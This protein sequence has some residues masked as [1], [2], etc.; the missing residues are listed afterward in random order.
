VPC[1]S[2]LPSLSINRPSA[3]PT[4][5]PHDKTVPLA[6]NRPVSGVIGRTIDILNSKVVEPEPLSII[7]LMASPMHVSRSVAEKS[8]CTVPS[9]LRYSL[10]G[11][12]VTTTLPFRA[13]DNVVSKRSGHG[14]QW[15]RSVHK[16][17]DELKPALCLPIL[18]TYDPIT[19]LAGYLHRFYDR[20]C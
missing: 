15:Q 10:L 4:R 1:E 14:V 11:S 6:L 18:Y 19:L 2:S 20:S 8:P 3:V 9:G 16:P 7:D 5:R 12:E 17:I 13:L